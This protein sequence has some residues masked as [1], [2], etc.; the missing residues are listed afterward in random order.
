[1]ERPSEQ[2]E[3]RR[4]PIVPAIKAIAKLGVGV[5]LLAVFGFLFL[6]SVRGARGEPY[7]I[8]S[9]SLAPEP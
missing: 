3:W 8:P 4:A 6:R 7:T 2:S 5:A 9:D 1:M